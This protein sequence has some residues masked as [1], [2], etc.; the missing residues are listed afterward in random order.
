MPRHKLSVHT[1]TFNQHGKLSGA[2][3]HAARKKL[4]T[5]LDN[6]LGPL[7]RK[8]VGIPDHPKLKNALGISIRNLVHHWSKAGTAGGVPGYATHIEGVSKA[9]KVIKAGG[10]IG[11]GLGAGAS[12]LRVKETCRTGTEEDCRKVKF[13]EAGK[14]GGALA[15]GAA[16][17][18]AGVAIGGGVCA[19]IGV[20]TVG[21]GGVIC[22]LVFVGLGSGVGGNY[23]GT[24]GES[25]GEVLYEGL[26]SAK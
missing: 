15:G 22:G 9:S 2:E 23:L 10:W 24:S 3:F 13:T 20:G 1:R 6:S 25:L 21:V 7:V 26:S 14:F 5:Q 8:G 19:A 11:V 12:G 18:M 4:M 16:G 17:G